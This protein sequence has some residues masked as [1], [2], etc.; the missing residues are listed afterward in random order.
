MSRRRSDSSTNSTQRGVEPSTSPTSYGA[1]ESERAVGKWL[2]ARRSHDGVVL[3]RRHPRKL[4][5][6]FCV[7]D[8]CAPEHGLAAPALVMLSGT[9][10]NVGEEVPQ[11]VYREAR[12]QADR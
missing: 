12:R 2:G 7:L 8:S 6:L 9:V 11:A 4:Y 10:K 5:R 3:T 1:G